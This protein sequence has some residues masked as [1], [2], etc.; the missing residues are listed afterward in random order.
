[1]SA[2]L[3]HGEFLCILEHGV[4]ITGPAGI[5]KSTVALELLDRG[6]QLIADD[7]V[8][9]QARQNLIFGH[10]P[11]LLKNHLALRDLGVLNVTDLFGDKACVPSHRLD[12]VIRLT[13]E[14]Q[15][16][17]PSIQVIQS[18]QQLLGIS[19]PEIEIFATPYRNLAL[20]IETAVKNHI[21]YKQGNDANQ[22]LIIK[23][24]HFL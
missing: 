17:P 18:E 9:F 1:M 4:F 8:F 20:I 13:Q 15:P 22:Q 10:C 3:A 12:L 2:T 14:T 16:R 5:G 23:Q 21:L 7:V 11:D 24:Q 6:H 19:V